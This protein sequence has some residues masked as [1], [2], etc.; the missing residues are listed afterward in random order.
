VRGVTDYDIECRPVFFQ[1]FVFV[2]DDFAGTVSPEYMGYGRDG[3]L[4][5]LD[6]LDA[7]RLSAVF[8]RYRPEDGNCCPADMQAV[9]LT[10]DRS[11]PVPVL[12]PEPEPVSLG[13]PPAAASPGTSWVDEL[14]TGWNVPGGVVPPPSDAAEVGDCG[15]VLR[16]P[17]TDADAQVAAAGWA[18]YGGYQTGWGLSVVHGLSRLDENCRPAS[19]QAFVFRDGVFAGTI[20]PEEM[21]AQTDGALEAVTVTENGG[22]RA[23]F[24]RWGPD[25]QGCCSEGYSA[26]DM[27]VPPTASVPVLV[28]LGP[29]QLLG[30]PPV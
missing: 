13:A 9:T 20:S 12:V 1:D 6:L 8:A 29:P 30:I 7:D 10:V 19:F 26:L 15:A 5:T 22:L 27:Q 21:A 25:H 18:L 24:Q 4:V 17:E 28:P 11:G 16:E 2:G 23:I 14:T 3:M